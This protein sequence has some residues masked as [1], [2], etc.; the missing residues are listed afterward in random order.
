VLHTF[1]TCCAAAALSLASLPAAPATTATTAAA[2][3]ATLAPPTGLAALATVVTRYDTASAGRGRG[4]NASA[5]RTGGSITTTTSGSIIIIIIIITFITT[6]TVTA[7]FARSVTSTAVITAAA[8]I[9]GTDSPCFATPKHVV[10]VADA[11]HTLRRRH[12]HGL[13]AKHLR[14]E[15][16]CV[17]LDRTHILVHSILLFISQQILLPKQRPQRVALLHRNRNDETPWS[18]RGQCMQTARTS[19][20]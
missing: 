11:V 13:R 9:H 8:S 17:L 18:D 1:G 12:H 16:V 14:R 20:F 3:A 10:V 4:T 6:T 19:R 2:A 15:V 7:T 5:T